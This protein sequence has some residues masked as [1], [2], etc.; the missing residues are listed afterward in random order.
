MTDKKLDRLKELKKQRD[1]IN[2]E[3]SINEWQGFKTRFKEMGL[4]EKVIFIIGAIGVVMLILEI[5]LV[6]L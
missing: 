6:L 1:K 4:L 2:Q 3:I 5:L